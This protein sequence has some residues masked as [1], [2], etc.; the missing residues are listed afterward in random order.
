MHAFKWPVI[1][2]E[3]IQVLPAHNKTLKRNISGIILSVFIIKQTQLRA[4][5]AVNLK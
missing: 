4:E 3:I 1:Y 2:C 5:N